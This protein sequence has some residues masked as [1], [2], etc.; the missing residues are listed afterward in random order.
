[1]IA[2]L[3][4]RPGARELLAS[5]AEDFE[6]MIFTASHESYADEVINYLDPRGEYVQHRLYR[7]NCE[8]IQ[9]GYY[10]KNLRLLGRDLS[11]VVLVDNAAY[12]YAFQV[13][14]GIPIIPYYEG[15]S[16]YEMKALEKY[17]R[18]LH[19]DVRERNK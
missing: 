13:A 9:E 10:V 6:I 1:M 5:L 11:K 15:K 14:N 4:I 16:D 7:R 2:P 17:L 12:S 19:G 3:N 18:S 8:Y